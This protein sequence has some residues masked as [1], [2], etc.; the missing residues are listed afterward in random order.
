MSRPWA[1][2]QCHGQG[3]LLS[4]FPLISLSGIEVPEV[5]EFQQAQE[6]VQ[7]F[8][9]LCSWGT[10]ATSSPE[11]HVPD[12]G[13]PRKGA[14]PEKILPDLPH[15]RCDLLSPGEPS[16]VR[17]LETCDHPQKR[18]LPAPLDRSHIQICPPDCKRYLPYGID[19]SAF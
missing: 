16:P 18:C 8:C 1:H 9:L 3:N 13:P 7:C 4:Q 5:P 12:Y 15:R 14:P 2:H 17:A 11:L 6:L 10:P 19:P